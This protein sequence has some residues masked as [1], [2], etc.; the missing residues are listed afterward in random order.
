VTT[1]RSVAE[2]LNDAR[3]PRLERRLLLERA[4]GLDYAA[5]LRAPEAVLET[6]TLQRYQTLLDRRLA[7][8]PMAHILGVRE[9]YGRDFRVDQRV[10]IP[11][12]ETEL[13]IELALER[14][15]EKPTSRLLDVGSGSGCIA[16]TMALE[17]PRATLH[18]I[19]ISA[20]ALE[21]ARQ[22]AR[23]LGATV[24]FTHADISDPAIFETLAE[25][26]DLILGNLPY[27]A[28]GDPHLGVGDLRFEPM[29]A[30]TDGKDGLSLI[31]ATV[32]FARERLTNG[33]AILLEHGYDQGEAVRR[34]LANQAFS[35]IATHPDLA[36]LERVS[37]GFKVR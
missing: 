28:K 17:A 10:L 25:D 16:I 13:L 31:A 32:H 33:G 3:L 18:A 9:F 35:Q 15:Q 2:V 7:G 20:N 4:S 11:R 5:M 29:Q 6:A 1:I 8:E 14:T 37:V 12:P 21:L 36:G 24:T 26:Y 27:I 34:L 19:D 22:N 30:L 23:I